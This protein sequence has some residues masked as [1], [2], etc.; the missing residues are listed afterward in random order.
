MNP[1]MRLLPLPGVFRPPSDAWMLA[2]CIRQEQ[3][4]PRARA[5]DICTGSGVLALA[6]ALA[7]IDDVTAVDIS[8][9]AV[10]AVRLNAR[11]NG[12][13]VRALHGDLFEP[14]AGER[15]DLIVSNPPYL[16]SVEDALPE[17]GLRRAIEGGP[18][19]R[20]FL[21]PICRQAPEHLRPGGVLLLVHSS[22]CG[23]HQ[24]LR[25]LRRS[26]LDAA[27]AFRHRGRLGPR[28][29]ARLDVLMERD[30][31]QGDFEEILVI[32]GQLQ[33]AAAT[34]SSRDRG[35]RRL[36]GVSA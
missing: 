8:R 34:R 27:V 4:P 17:D 16:P 5:L 15:F 28:M 6:A 10:L 36:E 32:R 29:R 30:L 11:L 14:V 20:A 22:A 1:S 25:A 35:G 9:R 21:D 26:G 3:L 31:V 23:E 24:T 2:R 12:L 18:D 19:G 7:G 13:R 33:A